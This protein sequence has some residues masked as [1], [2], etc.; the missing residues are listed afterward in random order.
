LEVLYC[1]QRSKAESTLT[2][3][4]HSPAPTG[5]RGAGAQVRVESHRWP[6]KRERRPL[7]D[8]IRGGKH[9]GG[10][11]SR[12]HGRGEG[13]T[14]RYLSRSVPCVMPQNKIQPNRSSGFGSDTFCRTG[15][16]SRSCTPLTARLGAA[17]LR[18]AHRRRSP[19]RHHK[20]R[21]FLANVRGSRSRRQ[22]VALAAQ[23]T[24]PSRRFSCIYH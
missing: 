18:S 23:V 4:C 15:F 1:E 19:A 3:C 7:A 12:V 13:G 5:D 22:D 21:A 6:R 20:R 17:E 16:K 11:A 14:N 2:A 10:Y 8:G 24:E 9:P